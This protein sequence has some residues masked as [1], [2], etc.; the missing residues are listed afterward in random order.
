[1][2]S[3]TK[4][5][6]DARPR[7][8]AC[9]A[10]AIIAPCTIYL[11]AV[12]LAAILPVDGAAYYPGSGAKQTW[13]DSFPFHNIAKPAFNR[14]A[15]S[16]WNIKKHALSYRNQYYYLSCRQYE[17]G[18]GISVT[19]GYEWSLRMNDDITS[20]N[21]QSGLASNPL[22]RLLKGRRSRIP[23]GINPAALL[24][25]SAA[26]IIALYTAVLLYRSI[27]LYLM[28]WRVKRNLCLACGYPITESK[29]CPE[30]GQTCG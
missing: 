12:A 27:V 1:M 20:F 30:C 17:S 8:K 15:Y 7:Y 13:P 18:L 5:A 16:S 22:Y 10:L 2:K 24:L 25:S 11:Q 9:I 28:G 14:T 3:L 26:L 4:M 6:W 19:S 21:G 29:I 23:V